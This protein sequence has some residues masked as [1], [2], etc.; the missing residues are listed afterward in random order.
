MAKNPY[1]RLKRSSYDDL[2]FKT[3]AHRQ[4]IIETLPLG[5]YNV[6]ITQDVL[7]ELLPVLRDYKELIDKEAEARRRKHDM[8]KR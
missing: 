3:R 4:G 1:G 2:V 5:D 7:S 8:S 6:Y